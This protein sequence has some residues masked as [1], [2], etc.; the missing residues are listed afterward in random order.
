MTVSDNLSK[1]IAILLLGTCIGAV[2]LYVYLPDAN[3]SGIDSTVSVEAS[4]IE[5][6]VAL[7]SKNTNQHSATESL[8]I[9]SDS[10]DS[11]TTQLQNDQI[12]FTAI[13]LADYSSV[14]DQ[15]RL[16]ENI[17]Q[18]DFHGI[19]EEL[20]NSENALET[21][22]SLYS[23]TF[24]DMFFLRWAE[25]DLDSALEFLLNHRVSQD[26]SIVSKIMRKHLD[27]LAM[28][29]QAQPLRW[30]DSISEA[31]ARKL[32]LS[33]AGLQWFENSDGMA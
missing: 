25:L 16:L 22:K 18:S 15:L 30:A 11:V 27:V 20:V 8:Q 2:G 33:A 31:N 3:D 12:N 1:N 32:A 29:D 24:I 9:S 5:K 23:T 14:I 4:L 13:G 17:S 21:Q 28:D 6:S 19:A 7:E 26:V 10:D